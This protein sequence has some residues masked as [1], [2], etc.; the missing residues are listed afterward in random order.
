MG[1]AGGSEESGGSAVAHEAQ[2]Q[3][4]L[5]G[6]GGASSAPAREARHAAD[7]GSSNSVFKPPEGENLPT[8]ELLRRSAGSE[9]IHSAHDDGGSDDDNDDIALCRTACAWAH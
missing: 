1:E 2:S 7:V 6:P 8:S 4:G 3:S 5:A 9:Q